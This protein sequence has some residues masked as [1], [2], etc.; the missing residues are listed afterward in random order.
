MLI[1]IISASLAV[2]IFLCLLFRDEIRAL[3][4]E[5]IKL[6]EK[7]TTFLDNAK[8]EAYDSYRK[9]LHDGLKINQGKDIQGVIPNPI[10]TMEDIAEDTE[11]KKKADKEQDLYNKAVNNLFSYDGNLPEDE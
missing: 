9:G 4:D 3:K 1:A 10:R 8:I 2:V 6:T 5:N 7:M 11:E